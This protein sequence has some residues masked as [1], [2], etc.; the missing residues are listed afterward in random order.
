MG[1]KSKQKSDEYKRITAKH[2]YRGY[3]S[4]RDRKL[5]AMHPV[6]RFSTDA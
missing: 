1:K 5:A 6:K 2:M 3:G 4:Y